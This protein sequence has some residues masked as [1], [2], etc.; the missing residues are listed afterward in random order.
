V[1]LRFQT[2]NTAASKTI[3]IVDDNADFRGSA[4]FWLE[5]E[6]YQVK[7][8][9]DPCQALNALSGMAQ[10]V[11]A[12][13]C[14]LL[15]VRMP[16][17]S[18]LDV[19]DALRERGVAL[20]VIYMSGHADVPLTVAAMQKGAVTLLEKPF[21]DAALQDALTRAF[22]HGQATAHR[23]EPIA[24]ER[25]ADAFVEFTRRER[26]LA[27]R[28]RQVLQ[29]VI[30]GIYNKNIADRLAL[31]IKT[32]ELYRARGMRKLQVHSVAELTRMMVSQRV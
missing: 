5:G 22:G 17:L 9:G 10:A 7:S 27:P 23:A 30:E 13:T 18:G 32:V 4:S 2:M 31:S 12:N 15:D 29:L 3:F 1:S 25:D 24:T 14:L 28:E 6:G 8:W 26:L 16:V 21:D 20:P 11:T 19:H